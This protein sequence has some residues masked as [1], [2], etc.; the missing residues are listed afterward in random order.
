[1]IIITAFEATP[2]AGTEAGLAWNWGRA[3]V[4]A[5]H[6]VTVVTSGGSTAKARTSAWN[7]AGIDVV[8][9]GEDSG[10]GAAQTPRQ[11]FLAER[12]FARWLLLCGSWLKA[13][14]AGATAVHHVCWGSVRLRPSFLKVEASVST[15]WGPLGGGQFPTFS[16]LSLNN[17]VHEGV[18]AASFPL[19]W[20]MRRHDFLR[21][22]SPT[23][24]LTTNIATFRFAES[25]GVGPVKAML[26]DGIDPEM[27]REAPPKVLDSTVRLVWLGRMVASKR[28]DIAVGVVAALAARGIPATLTMI[29]DG[30]ERKSLQSLAARL[31]IAET[32][33]FVGRIPWE[34]T[35]E[36]YDKSTF[37]LF[38]SMRDSS[39][40]AVLE[41]A[42]R[43]VP[44]LCLRRQGV[45]SMVPASVAVGPTTFVSRAA[46]EGNLADLVATFRRDPVLYES[47]SRHAI[48]FA[49]S[50]TWAA[51]VEF[52]L[53]IVSRRSVNEANRGI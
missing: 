29:G 25:I 50:Q 52:V 35:F 47:A 43:G 17:Y 5:G 7:E 46:L 33:T 24:T 53:R 41:A 30:P 22:S 19:A 21:H 40:P 12:A 32:V 2:G 18:R 10:I 23:L 14:S 37:L 44:T 11:L 3:Y 48:A 26:A 34:N 6:Q 13:N 49:K 4:D 1:M 20:L 16:G 15:I 9:L 45:G 8:F 31:G 42:A 27:I 28:A 51:K 38:T 36:Y 39:C